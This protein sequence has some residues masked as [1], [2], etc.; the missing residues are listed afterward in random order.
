M[1]I[2]LHMTRDYAVQGVEAKVQ[3]MSLGVMA[4]LV[5]Y[6]ISVWGFGPKRSAARQAEWGYDFERV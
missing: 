2:A 6:N 4:E 1:P 5:R 3:T